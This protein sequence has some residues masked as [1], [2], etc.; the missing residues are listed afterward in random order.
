[1]QVKVS[2]HGH[3]RE[4]AGG[5]GGSSSLTLEVGARLEDVLLCLGIPRDQVGF[6]TRNGLMSSID[7]RLE[8]GDKVGVYPI[9]AGG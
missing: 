1:M 9:L 5:A 2:V 8:D 6:V 7:C 4:L 3:L